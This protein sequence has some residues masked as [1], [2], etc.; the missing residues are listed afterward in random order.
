[1]NLII[2]TFHQLLLLLTRFI[3]FFFSRHCN[4]LRGFACSTVVEY[5]QQEGFYSVPLPATRKTPNLEDQ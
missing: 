4:P 5:S 3:F 1:M 2:G